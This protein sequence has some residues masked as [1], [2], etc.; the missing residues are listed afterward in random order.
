MRLSEYD[1]VLL[2]RRLRRH[3]FRCGLVTLRCP[4][5]KAYRN[6]DKTY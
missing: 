3:L 5:G 4:L 1:H 2:I 6:A